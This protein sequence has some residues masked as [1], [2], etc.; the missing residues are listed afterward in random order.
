MSLFTYHMIEAL[1]GYAN[2]PEG[3]KEVLASETISYVGRKVPQ[4]AQAA[5]YD[6]QTPHARLDGDFPIAML[7]GG[8][9]VSKGMAMPDPLEAPPTVVSAMTIDTGGGAL[10]TGNVNTGGGAFVG[11]DV[12]IG[13]DYVKGDKVTGDV[14]N[15]G[16]ISGSQG[17]AIGRGSSVEIQHGMGSDEAARLFE[18]VYLKIETRPEDPSVEKEEL[19]QTVERIQDEAGRGGQANPGKIERWLRAL[20]EAAPDILVA[21]VR[22][23]HSSRV[24]PSVQGVAEKFL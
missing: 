13:G 23:L 17:I 16:N 15:V 8:K 21:T 5:G 10:I 4:S 22:A 7:L 14:I 11:R 19:K 12:N 24:N 2:P 1:T 6:E 20:G 3:A 9:G 18:A